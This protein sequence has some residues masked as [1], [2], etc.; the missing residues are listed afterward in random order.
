MV[1]EEE[2]VAQHHT[3]DRRS[4][5]G[6]DSMDGDAGG[7]NDQC[8]RAGDHMQRKV[9]TL[10]SRVDDTY[11][12]LRSEETGLLRQQGVLHRSRQSNLTTAEGIHQ[13]GNTIILQVGKGDGMVLVF[14][15]KERVGGLVGINDLVDGVHQFVLRGVVETDTDVVRMV[16]EDM[17]EIVVQDSTGLQVGLSIKDRLQLKVEVGLQLHPDHHLEVCSAD[18]QVIIN[19]LKHATTLHA[20]HAEPS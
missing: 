7:V 5:T 8:Q 10:V 4:H 16:G 19:Q 13:R 6:S 18:R 9:D 20:Y 12:A 14:R 11:L 3:V 17:A 2:A 15:Q 1:V